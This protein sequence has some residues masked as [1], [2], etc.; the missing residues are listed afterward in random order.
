MTWGAL[1]VPPLTV[2]V[3]ALEEERDHVGVVPRCVCVCVCS[4]ENRTAAAVRANMNGLNN[5]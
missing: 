3:C 2:D 5:S 4:P 1:T